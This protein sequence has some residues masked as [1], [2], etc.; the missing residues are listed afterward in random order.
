MFGWRWRV[1]DTALGRWESRDPLYS[2]DG[3]NAYQ[4]VLSAPL[5]TVDPQGL[6]GMVVWTKNKV[7]RIRAVASGYGKGLKRALLHL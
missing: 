1:L 3:M 5:V 7:N 6:E 4:Y 2:V